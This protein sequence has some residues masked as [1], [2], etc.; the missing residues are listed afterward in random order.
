MN[1]VY[2]LG[3][4][5]LEM[6]EIAKVLRSSDVQFRDENLGWDDSVFAR[7]RSSVDEILAASGTPVLVEIRE[8]PDSY[9]NRVEVIDHHGPNSADLTSLEQVLARLGLPPTRWQALVAAND[10]GHIDGLLALSATPEEIRQVRAADRRAQ[11][12]T[13][14][15][16]VQA[17]HAI[18][19]ADSPTRGLTVVQLPHARMATVADRLHAASGG[20]GFG[21]LLVVSPR[22]I[23]FSGDGWL[24]ERLHA[25][26]GG[27]YGG[28]LPSRGF[29]GLTTDGPGIAD[30][31]RH[32]IIL[33]LAPAKLAFPV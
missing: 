8:I 27:F 29:W 16:E 22:E 31:V 12:I 10:K 4:H 30:A 18:A 21:N 24:V 1:R 7:Y 17:E 11:G 3:G 15:E 9:L 23:N 28:N 2:L 6:T 33:E 14:A 25:A 20:P 13:A 26:F 5:D 19:R 32:V